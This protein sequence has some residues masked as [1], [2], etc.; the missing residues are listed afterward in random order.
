MER[1]NIL[2]ALGVGL[3]VLLLGALFISKNT[4]LGYT[5]SAILYLAAV[6]GAGAC[7]LGRGKR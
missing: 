1:K 4:W 6:L 2:S 5:D 3:G 7:W